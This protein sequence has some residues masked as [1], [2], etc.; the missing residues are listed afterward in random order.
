ML[1]G[2]HRNPARVAAQAF[3]LPEPAS[4]ASLPPEV[5]EW[6]RRAA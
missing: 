2:D 4:P 3:G 1:I 6:A 5:A